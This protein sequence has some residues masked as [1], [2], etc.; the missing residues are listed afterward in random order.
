MT[1]QEEIKKIF[2]SNAS[3]DN[4]HNF[5]EGVLSCL[6][7]FEQAKEVYKKEPVWNNPVTRT[8]YVETFGRLYQ[9][10]KLAF[11]RGIITEQKFNELASHLNDG[12]KQ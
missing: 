2:A 3:S 11:H 6:D 8:P 5:K 1:Y 10:L 4:Q 9:R 7:E 12:L